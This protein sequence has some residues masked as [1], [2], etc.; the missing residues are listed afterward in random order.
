MKT[1]QLSAL[2][3]AIDLRF[4]RYAP[5]QIMFLTGSAATGELTPSSDL[6]LLVLFDKLPNAYRESFVFRHWN[7]EAFVHDHETLRYFFHTDAT[8]GDPVVL[9]MIVDGI[10]VPEP[11]DLSRSLQE[12]AAA[13][14][15]AGPRPLSDEQERRVRYMITSLSVDLRDPRSMGEVL[16]TGA[17]L[18]ELVASYYLRTSHRWAASGKMIPRRLHEANAGF[19]AEFEAAF[20]ELFA[21]RPDQLLRL[22]EQMLAP[23]GGLLFDGYRYD[24]PEAWRIPVTAQTPNQ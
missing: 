11:S 23:R 24:A 8:S 2:Q 6:D 1:L 22:V 13:L 18:Y 14:L 4:G 3:T 15:N 19:G 20:A 21:G 10:P 9:R 5:A 7:I 16:A 12:F 17:A